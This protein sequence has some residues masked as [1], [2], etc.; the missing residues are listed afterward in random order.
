QKP[1]NNL[2][3]SQA[4]TYLKEGHFEAGSMKPKIEAAIDFL[5]S[6]TNTKK[7]VIITSPEHIATAIV[8]KK[9]GTHIRP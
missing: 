1:L 7:E 5:S 6:E 4:K 9:I 8:N 3:L 2:T